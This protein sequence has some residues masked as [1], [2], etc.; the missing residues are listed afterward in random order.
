M[1]I[2]WERADHNFTEWSP[3]L[4]TDIQGRIIIGQITIGMGQTPPNTLILEVR[5]ASPSGI[6]H[7]DNVELDPQLIRFGA[8]NI[9]TASREVLLSLPGI[10]PAI[11]D[12]IIAG[13]PYGDRQ[14]KGRGIGD[15]LVG[16]ILSSD[17][18]TKLKLFQRLAHL[19]TVRSDVFQIVS[20]GQ[21]V[22][23][24]HGQ[25]TQRIVTVVQR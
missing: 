3:P 11:A 10:T 22:E 2:R 21:A 20:V 5:C 17:E 6:C 8:V 24:E 15:L 23:K 7:T 1:S 19:L 14:Q 9:N 25:A 13:Q 12:R 18:Q 16:D 4:L